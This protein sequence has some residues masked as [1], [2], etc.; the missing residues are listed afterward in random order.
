M[1]GRVERNEESKRID[2]KEGR[3]IGWR[4]SESL[5]GR[6]NEEEG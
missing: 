3:R 2:K 1:K 6:Y 4:W 5:R